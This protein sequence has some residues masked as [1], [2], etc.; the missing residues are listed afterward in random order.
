MKK[1]KPSLF[2]LALTGTL[3]TN[4]HAASA[5]PF[6]EPLTVD[7]SAATTSAPTPTAQPS[8]TVDF[9][10][11]PDGRAWKLANE[12]NDGTMGIQQ[13][14]LPDEKPDL[15]TE[16]FTIH[17]YYNVTVDPQQYSDAF[18]K[19]LQK[20]D[21]EDKIEHRVISKD[22][23]NLLGEWWIAGG[24]KAQHEWYRVITDGKNVVVIRYTTRRVKSVEADR[25]KWE[26]ILNSA[27]I[28]PN[29]Q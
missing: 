8:V 18:I 3:F 21:P 2:A 5:P 29:K 19:E 1:L 12:T 17:K 20:L 6:T 13:Y 22:A 4:L 15:W 10:L 23:N 16:L 11:A 9:S 28:V 14:V 25:A 26:G 7:D 27:K 24:L